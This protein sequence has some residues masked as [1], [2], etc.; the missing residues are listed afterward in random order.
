MARRGMPS[1]EATGVADEA[2]AVAVGEV[3]SSVTGW[4]VELPPLLDPCSQITYRNGGAA[5]QV[6]VRFNKAWRRPPHD[7]VSAAAIGTI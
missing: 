1:A 2:G 5:A 4:I 6:F 7:L 3:L